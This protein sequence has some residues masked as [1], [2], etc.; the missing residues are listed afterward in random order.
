[1]RT[2]WDGQTDGQTDGLTDGAGYI[3]PAAELGGSKKSYYLY[4]YSLNLSFL[5][6]AFISFV[7]SFNYTILSE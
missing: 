3:G 7:L 5:P 2:W 1:M 4:R 6:K